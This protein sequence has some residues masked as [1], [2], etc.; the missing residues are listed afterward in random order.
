MQAITLDNRQ[1]SFVPDHPTPGAAAGETRLR[2]QLAGICETDLQLAE[3][4]MGFS[5][6]PGHEFVAV[7]DEGRY[8]GRRVVAEINCNCR[9]C[10]TCDAGRPT[11]CPHRTVL[12]IDRHDGAFAEWIRV[13]EHCVHP[14]PDSVSNDQAVFVEPL[15]AAFQVLE[16]VDVH[17]GDRVAVLGDGRLGFLCAQ[18]LMTRT[19]K[20]TVFG[21]HAEKL[22][23]FAERGQQTEQVAGSGDDSLPSNQFSLVVDC[24]GST[25]GL[26]MAIDLVRPRG[27]IVLKTTVAKPHH[28]SLAAIVIDEITVVGSRCGPFRRAIEALEDR[29]VDVSDLITHRYRLDQVGEA[30]ETATH[31]EAFK[32][33]F[34]IC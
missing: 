8:A 13:P 26:P 23:R 9:R 30:F 21:K 22:K 19:G 11:H 32:V 6:V 1:L 4:Y 24:T 3:G 33:V 18:T 27:T 28:Q 17:S 2:V 5:G 31:A 12:G 7:A 10:K 14:L 20:V 15:A 25:T 29:Q 34:D 16:Q